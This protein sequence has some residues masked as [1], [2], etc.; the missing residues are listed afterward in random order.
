MKGVMVIA[1]KKKEVVETVEPE[2]VSIAPVEPNEKA[3]ALKQKQA[4]LKATEK[5][6][7]EFLPKVHESRQAM[8]EIF[9]EAFQQA[10][11]DD[12]FKKQVMEWIVK[13]PKDATSAISTLN[14]IAGTIVKPVQA[15][16]SA[17]KRRRYAWKNDKG[18]TAMV[19]E[20]V[21][22]IGETQE[23]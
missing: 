18:Q 4:Q 22:I 21:E 6:L 10:S 12:G 14:A 11:K 15:Q 17:R 20:E 2:I 1:R 8:V 19:E 9:F 5:D 13:H 7:D 16:T 3:I 23:A